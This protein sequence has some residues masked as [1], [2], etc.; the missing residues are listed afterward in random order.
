MTGRVAT[1]DEIWRRILWSTAAVP[2]ARESRVFSPDH[3]GRTIQN[4]RDVL[5]NDS[6]T[7]LEHGNGIALRRQSC[8]LWALSDS[9]GGVS[10]ATH[11]P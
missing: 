11:G 8:N 9:H 7:L 4:A 3:T 6:N 1:S 10:Q 2:V 5:D